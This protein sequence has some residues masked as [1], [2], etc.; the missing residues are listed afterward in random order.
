MNDLISILTQ[1]IT[2]FCLSETNFLRHSGRGTKVWWILKKCSWLQILCT[3]QSLPSIFLFLGLM[4]GNKFQWY[5][6]WFYFIVRDVS[7][8]WNHTLN[9]SSES[10]P[11]NENFL[12][13]QECWMLSL[14]S[15]DSL[16]RAGLQFWLLLQSKVPHLTNILDLAKLIFPS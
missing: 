14:S 13:V 6:L 16:F 4:L 15:L 12:R 9:L 3:G 1:V 8:L 2:S 5:I 10:C 11:G 7:L